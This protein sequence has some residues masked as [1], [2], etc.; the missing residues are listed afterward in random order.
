MNPGAAFDDV[1]HLAAR[2]PV[3]V[4]MTA[5]LEPDEAGSRLLGGLVQRVLQ[6]VAVEPALRRLHITSD[7]VGCFDHPHL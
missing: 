4:G 5:G 3:P 2:M 1:D 6:R 7:A